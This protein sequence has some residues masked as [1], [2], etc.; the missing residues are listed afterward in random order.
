MKRSPIDL[1][2]E[3]EDKNLKLISEIEISIN[4]DSC[5]NFSDAEI[6]YLNEIAKASPDNARFYRRGESIPNRPIGLGL[7]GQPLPSFNRKIQYFK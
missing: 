6:H 2:E 3:K 4:Y 7:S 5:S 1:T